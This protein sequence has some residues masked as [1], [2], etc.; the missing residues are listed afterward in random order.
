MVSI[1]TVSHSVDGEESAMITHN[2]LNLTV[3][4]SSYLPPLQAPFLQGP[5]LV[6]PAGK[7]SRPVQACSLED[8]PTSADV[9]W[10][11]TVAQVVDE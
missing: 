2:A 1:V 6:T 7:D 10:L 9:L 3:Q 8:R 4:G 5:V 11:A